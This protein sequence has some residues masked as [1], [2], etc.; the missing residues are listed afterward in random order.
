MGIYIGA[1]TTAQIKK[2][3]SVPVESMQPGD[4]I[5][6]DW[7][8]DG[9]PNHVGICSAKDEMIDEHGSNSDPNNLKEDE[10][11]RRKSLSTSYKSQILDVR[12]IIQDDGSI[13]N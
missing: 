3:I 8:K 11:V 7:D 13:I 9:A 6:F 12:R 4:L 2:G 1:N 5:L 10:N